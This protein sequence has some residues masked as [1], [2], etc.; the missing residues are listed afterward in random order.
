M[1]LHSNELRERD[2]KTN[3]EEKVR[4]TVHHLVAIPTDFLRTNL[5]PCCL[6]NRKRESYSTKQSNW[7]PTF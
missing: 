4:D 1:W 7:V 5:A 2:N 3:L 6:R